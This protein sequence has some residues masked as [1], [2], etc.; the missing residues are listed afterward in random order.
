M[1]LIGKYTTSWN[2]EHPDSVVVIDVEKSKTKWNGVRLEVTPYSSHAQRQNRNPFPNSTYSEIIPV[3]TDAFTQFFDEP[4]LKM[5][6]KTL[7][8]S[9]YEYLV[10]TQPSFGFDWQTIILSLTAQQ[11]GW[12]QAPTDGMRVYNETTQTFQVWDGTSF[13]EEE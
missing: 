10:Q 2:G 5:T 1:S 6:G 13:V 8:E 3:D 12:I 11:I 9:A 4:V 7:H